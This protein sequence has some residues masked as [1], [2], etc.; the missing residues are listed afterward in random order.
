MIKKFS[1]AITP[2]QAQELCDLHKRIAG[3][4]LSRQHWELP[5]IQKCLDLI[6]KI[7]GPFIVDHAPSYIALEQN[8]AG[9]PTHADGCVYTAKGWQPN[10][11]PWCKWSASVLVSDPALCS[12]G[13]VRFSELSVTPAEHYCSLYVWPSNL[14][15]G[16]T[17]ALH[18]VDPH[19]G[20][21]VVLLFFLAISYLPH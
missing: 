6:E 21:R 11:M 18:S 16:Y 3:Q 12:G 20:H 9:H 2:Q 15:S 4:K 10:H 14:D 5:A 7:T 1:N 13:V 19:N 17:P 8:T